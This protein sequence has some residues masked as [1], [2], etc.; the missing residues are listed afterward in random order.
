M[1]ACTASHISRKLVEVCAKSGRLRR[2]LKLYVYILIQ[3]G[4]LEFIKQTRLL[5]ISLDG[6]FWSNYL[7]VDLEPPPK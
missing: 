6:V 7:L 3:L 1:V 5:A 4:I 2:N